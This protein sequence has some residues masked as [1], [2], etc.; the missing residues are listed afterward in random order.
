MRQQRRQRT[1]PTTRKK[2]RKC[3]TQSGEF[4]NRYDFAYIGRAIVN[5]PGKVASDF[6]KNASSEKLIIFHSK[7]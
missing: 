5:Q 7:E 1:R 2:H 4:L 3:R 6:I